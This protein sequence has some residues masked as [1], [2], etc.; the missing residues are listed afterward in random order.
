MNL[1]AVVRENSRIC[2]NVDGE[3]FIINQITLT[4]EKHTP[5]TGTSFSNIF[6]VPRKAKRAEGFLGTLEIFDVVRPYR[7]RNIT[8]EHD[9][10]CYEALCLYSGLRAKRT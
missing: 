1:S 3:C 8:L 10:S 7:V 9:L 6:E 4:T 2:V 5:N